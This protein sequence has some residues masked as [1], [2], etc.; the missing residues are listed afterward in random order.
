[1]SYLKNKKVYLIVIVMILSAGALSAYKVY[2]SAQIVETITYKE[3]AAQIGDIKIE[4]TIDGI[5]ELPFRYMDFENQGE[6]KEIYFKEGDT[7]NK[8]EAV[9]KQNDL[10]AA[11]TL[12]KARLAYEKAEINYKDTL[13]KIEASLQDLETK[14]LNYKQQ[15][16][17]QKKNSYDLEQQIHKQENNIELMELTPDDYALIDIENAKRD[18]ES[19]K[20][21]LETQKNALV[22]AQR[23]LDL[24]R[25]E[26]DSSAALSSISLREAKITL[27][28]AEAKLEQTNMYAREDGRILTITKDVGQAVAAISSGAGSADQSFITYIATNEPYVIKLA[29]P[30]FDLVSVNVGQKA[31]VTVEGFSEKT[32]M[33]K[34]THLSEIPKTDNN[35]VVTYAATVEL[36]EKP[37]GLKNGMNAVVSIISKDV[38]N[39]VIVPNNTVYFENGKQYVQVKE[40]EGNIQ[41]VTI[42]TGFSDGTSAEVKEGLKGN[43]TLISKVQVST[44]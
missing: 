39:V 12:E 17:M 37:E 11:Q 30:E 5:V 43:E 3:E 10:D 32:L 24:L 40:G 29:I 13:S 1:M 36:D 6:I 28:N 25:A 8:G 44:K 14:K 19:L 33:G 34:V 4:Y 20:L 41:K 42:I 9:A 16:E 27:E 26:E 2:K 22:L 31:E 38:S 23:D 15:I 7:F 35:Q 21:N 18:L